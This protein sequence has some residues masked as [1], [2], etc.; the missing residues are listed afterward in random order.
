[1]IELEQNVQDGLI[2]VCNAMTIAGSNP[3]LAP[4]QVLDL[5]ATLRQRE[6]RNRI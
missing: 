6:P 2:S 5:A 4:H 3:T 1:M